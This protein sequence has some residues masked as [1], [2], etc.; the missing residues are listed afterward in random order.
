MTHYLQNL[1]E[2]AITNATINESI[3]GNMPKSFDEVCQLLNLSY[4]TVPINW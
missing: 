4:K 3:S 2:T 1:Y